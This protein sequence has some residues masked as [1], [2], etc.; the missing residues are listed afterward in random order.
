MKVGILG[1]TFDPIHF[2]HIRPAQEVKQQLNL[3]EV[4]LMP[5]HIPPHKQSTHVSCEDRLAMA[6]LVSDELPQFK[7]CDI[8]AKRDSPSYSAMTLAQ[9]RE[10]HPQHEFYFI[11]GMDSFLNIS[12]WYEWQ[13]LFS[14]CHIVVCKR[15]GWQLDSNDPIQTTLKPR[16]KLATQ[17]TD[18][19]AG[20]IFILNVA[21]QDISSTQVRQQLMQG[22]IPSAA[23][24]ASI[25]DYIQHN[26]L[27]RGNSATNSD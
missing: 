23:L 15:P 27:Y 6:Q 8:E 16:R 26:R 5:N 25:Q 4:W 3:D 21:E 7:V 24:P 18:G 19:T 14:L 12:K 9:L 17:A 2:G 13:K 10:I 11:M 22:H 20:N 1:G